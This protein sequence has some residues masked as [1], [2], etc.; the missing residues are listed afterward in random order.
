M[1]KIINIDATIENA[2][3]TKKRKLDAENITDVDS[4]LKFLNINKTAE[5]LTANEVRGIR[6]NVWYTS[7]P[8]PLKRELSDIFDK[9]SNEK[10]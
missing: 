1:A 7:L 3:W 8:G 2:D 9:I 5:T 4:L 10:L 6:N